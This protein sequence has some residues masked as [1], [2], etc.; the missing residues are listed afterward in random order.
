MILLEVIKSLSNQTRLNIL[1]WLK[2]PFAHFPAEELA[3]Y[4]PDLGVCVSDIAKK[5]GMSV[6]TVSVYLKTMSTANILIST[7]KDQWTYYKRN[8]ES[9]QELARHIKNNL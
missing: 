1:E 9:I 2:E 8:E 4:S 3:D 6:P 7:R 5:A